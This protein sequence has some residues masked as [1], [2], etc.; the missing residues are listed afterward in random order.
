M[1]KGVFVGVKGSLRAEVLRGGFLFLSAT[2]EE[3]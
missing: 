3:V 1:D 2:D